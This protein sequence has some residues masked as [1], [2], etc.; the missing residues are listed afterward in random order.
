MQPRSFSSMVNIRADRSLTL[1]EHHVVRA[2]FALLDRFQTGVDRLDECGHFERNAVRDLFYPAFDDPIHRADVL[3]ET[4]AGR[5]EARRDAH[6]FIDG[7]C[8]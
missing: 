3:R 4:A 7:H 8:A 2:R 1:H 5:F 6:F